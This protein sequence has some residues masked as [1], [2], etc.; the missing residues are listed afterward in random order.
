MGVPPVLIHLWIFHYKTNHFGFMIYQLA[1]HK[2]T[3]QN[4]PL[5]DF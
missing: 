2:A 4:Q 1:C 5:S 3:S